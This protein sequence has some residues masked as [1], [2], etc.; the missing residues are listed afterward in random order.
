[1]RVANPAVFNGVP[2]LPVPGAV[3]ASPPPP[4]VIGYPCAETVIP[5]AT[6]GMGAATSGNAPTSGSGL[7]YGGASPPSNNPGGQ[8]RKTYEWADGL[9]VVD[10]N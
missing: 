9:T 2:L 4:T 3:P 6:S 7:T 10:L 8:T 1:M 5:A